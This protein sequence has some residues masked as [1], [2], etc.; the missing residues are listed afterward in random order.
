[1]LA[2]TQQSSNDAIIKAFT[3]YYRI[4]NNITGG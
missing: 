2:E 3:K 1:M 4:L